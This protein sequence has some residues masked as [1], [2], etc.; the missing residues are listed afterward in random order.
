MRIGWYR[1]VPLA[2]GP[3]EPPYLTNENIMPGGVYSADGPDGIG[4]QY[5]E[6]L[7]YMRQT[8]DTWIVARSFP[9]NVAE[10]LQLPI[11]SIRILKSEV[12]WATIRVEAVEPVGL[13]MRDT[14]LGDEDGISS[15]HPAFLSENPIP[16]AIRS[17]PVSE[18]RLWVRAK[19]TY[20]PLAEPNAIRAVL[21]MPSAEGRRLLIVTAMAESCYLV[22]VRV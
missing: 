1:G 18:P 8:Q 20:H 21:S 9:T 22:H 7:E 6:G 11:A 13:W 2:A 5:F 19:K 16:K 17:W 10:F 4:D 15:V 14:T 12:V 3:D